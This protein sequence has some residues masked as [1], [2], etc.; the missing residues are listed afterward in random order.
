MCSCPLYTDFVNRL[1]AT[2]YEAASVDIVRG[3]R[4]C[5]FEPKEK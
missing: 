5:E 3:T 1:E 4:F 2:R